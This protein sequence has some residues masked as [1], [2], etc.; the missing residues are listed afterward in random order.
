MNLVTKSVKVSRVGDHVT[1]EVGPNSWTIT[2]DAL[3]SLADGD[4]VDA[5]QFMLLTVGAGLKSAGVNLGNAAAVKA[6]IEGRTWLL[7]DNL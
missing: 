1:F 5:F 7:W 4:G 6:Y 3:R 2:A